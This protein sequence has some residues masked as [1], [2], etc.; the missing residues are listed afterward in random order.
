MKN[1]ELVKFKDG[2][3][4]IRKYTFFGITI[5]YKDLAGSSNING[6]WWNMGGDFFSSCRGTKER[7]EEVF[8][9]LT[10]EGEPVK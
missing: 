5:S 1:M 3:Y 7:A 9:Y 10:D 6:Y 8:E 4:G 2:S